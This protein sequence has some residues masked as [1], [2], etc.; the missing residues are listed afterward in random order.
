MAEASDSRGHP[1]RSPPLRTSLLTAI[2][3]VVVLASA[4]CSS[5]SDDAADEGAAGGAIATTTILE[6]ASSSSAVT[7]TTP[8]EVADSAIEVVL[9]ALDAKNSLDLDGWLTAFEGGEHQGTPLFAEEL[10]MNANQ[11]WEVVEPCQVTRE[12]ANGDTVVECLISNTDDFWGSGGIFDTRAFE[13]SVNPDGLITS[14]VGLTPGTRGFSSGR[15][16]TLNRAFS[17]WL[18][19]T[20]PDVFADT[21]FLIS[22][23]GPGFD[24]RDSTHMLVAVEYVEEFVAQSDD[25]PLDATES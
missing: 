22:S 5:T 3:T 11:H 2:V 20:Y 4:G 8:D 25:Y 9:A 23:N 14:Q 6:E 17:Q 15:R 7:T 24:A 19:D 12:N 10:L 21:G 16:N 18:S 13:F 1:H